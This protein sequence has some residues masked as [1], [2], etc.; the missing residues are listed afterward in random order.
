MGGA[1]NQQRLLERM[2]VASR[3]EKDVDWNAVIADVDGGN[4]VT[5]STPEHYFV[6]SD[7][8][9][10]AK[11]FNVGASG[12][13][14]KGGKTWMT[15][16]EIVRLGKGT[17]GALFLDHPAGPGPSIAASGGDTV[18][19][20]LTGAISQARIRELVA[21][22]GQ[23]SSVVKPGTDKRPMTINGFTISGQHE[24]NPD[25]TWEVTFAD[26]T[27]IDVKGER[28]SDNAPT[29]NWVPT[30][31][32]VSALTVKN[33]PANEIWERQPDGSSVRMRTNPKTG[34]KEPVLRA[35]GT[36][37]TQAAPPRGT[38][39]P[40][41]GALD[42]A[43]INQSNAAADLARARTGQV[44][45]PTPLDPVTRDLRMAQADAADALTTYRETQNQVE[46]RKLLPMQVV[47]LQQQETT[48]KYL[49]DGI[50]KG[51]WDLD[52]ANQTAT[53]VRQYT[54]AIMA[55]AKSPYDMWKDQEAERRQ[56]A[57]IGK[58]ILN[59]R[60][61][62]ASTLAGNLN[63]NYTSL[64]TANGGLR[65]D[66]DRVARSVTPLQTAADYTDQ[67]GGGAEVN[68]L[69]KGLLMALGNGGQAPAPSR[70]GLPAP[71]PAGL[72]DDVESWLGSLGSGEG[73]QSSTSS[74]AL[75]DDVESWL[76]S[77]EP[78]M[79]GV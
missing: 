53:Q 11:T 17:N 29:G 16:A 39:T 49:A 55:G 28:G 78:E 7:Y 41:N 65:G 64:L 72:P 74:S 5:I 56:Q 36:P 32:D 13:A 50:E 4:P 60:V 77:L 67:L 57:E 69:A 2:G 38:G 79:A 70:P 48:I 20:E 25:P 45:K 63:S 58:S 44:G 37:E 22:H 19:D 15:Q 75:P 33:L 12:T 3:L 47:A 51:W 73:A 35:D 46:G 24:D 10:E 62:S 18:S 40:R 27:K 76:G 21:A 66:P 68:G 54:D 6:V 61:S 42:A 59:Q 23:Y 9:P 8:D 52:Y 30:G 26:G 43:N 71:S 34:V 1:A 14:F 31:G